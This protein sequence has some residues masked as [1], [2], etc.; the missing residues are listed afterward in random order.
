MSQNTGVKDVSEADFSAEVIEASR[1][2]PIL[3]DF[4]AEWCGPCRMVGPVAEALAAA[5]EYRERF[6]LVKINTD[7]NPSLSQQFGISSIPAFK[8]FMDGEVASEFI[9][10]LPE[11]AL[12]RFLDTNLPDP[13]AVEIATLAKTDL[14][15]A[16]QKVLET[17]AGGHSAED[18][19][20]HAALLRMDTGD[21][22]YEFLSGIPEVG[23]KFSDARAA[24]L[25]F[26]QHD[27]EVDD[28]NHLKE[29]LDHEETGD[30]QKIRAAL[31]YFLKKV[32]DARPDD[33]KQEK[34]DMLLAFQ[35]LGNSGPLVDEYRRKLS[36]ILF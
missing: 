22:P 26:L 14:I 17:G 29:L 19:L 32:E 18:I 9:G 6:R 16:A 5:P 8:L 4:W 2:I 21:D 27:P 30:E 10:A 13:R 36:S 31:D 25:K 24:L 28:R 20:W 33:R 7:Q 11:Q 23:G 34:D 1:T 15:A 12:R 35:I 3:V